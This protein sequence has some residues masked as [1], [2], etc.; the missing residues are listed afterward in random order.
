MTKL[1]HAHCYYCGADIGL[2][3]RFSDRFDTCGDRECER[4][5]RDDAFAE[6]DEAHKQLDRNMGWGW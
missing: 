1:T 3:D 6:R 5:A 4:A 2:K